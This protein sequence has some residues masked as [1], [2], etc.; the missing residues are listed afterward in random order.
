MTPSNHPRQFELT[1]WEDTLA[2]HP[3]WDIDR[4]P[5]VRLRLALELLNQ[6]EFITATLNRAVDALDQNVGS[7]HA[8]DPKQHA[9]PIWSQPAE[10]EQ[11]PWDTTKEIQQTIELLRTEPA[12]ALTL[13]VE[14]Q[15]I[16]LDTCKRLQGTP[17]TDNSRGQ[18]AP[19]SKNRFDCSDLAPSLLAGLRQSQ[20]LPPEFAHDLVGR[21]SALYAALFDEA[22]RVVAD[23]H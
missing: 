23:I 16:S 21:L 11:Q 14:L 13:I 12:P 15:A 17:D 10:Q 18:P 2:F 1:R 8:I 5:S 4:P 9:S 20:S 3:A 19:S 22:L 7:A 6:L